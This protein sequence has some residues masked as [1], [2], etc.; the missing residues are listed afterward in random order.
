MKS[1]T[2]TTPSVPVGQTGFFII[3]LS[4]YLERRSRFCPLIPFEFKLDTFEFLKLPIGRVFK[5]Q[6]RSTERL[7]PELVEG[8][9]RSPKSKIQNGIRPP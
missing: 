7:R 1:C 3:G 8:S 4:I 5:I 2:Q 6:N 9:R